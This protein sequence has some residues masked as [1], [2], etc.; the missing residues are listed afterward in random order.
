MPRSL[1]PKSALKYKHKTTLPKNVDVY[2]SLVRS[3]SGKTEMS[4]NEHQ[5]QLKIEYHSV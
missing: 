4:I 2:S 5:Q 3:E 1:T